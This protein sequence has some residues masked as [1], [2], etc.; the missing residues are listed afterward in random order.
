MRPDN[1]TGMITAA[2]RR[3]EL[4]RAKAVQ[5]LRELDRTGAPVAFDA[6]ARAAGIFRS[7]LYGEADLRAEIQR[8][9]QTTRRSP[10]PPI[11]TAQRASDASL[12]T[13]LQ[14]PQTATARSAR[15]T[16]GYAANSPK[17]SASSARR[18]AD[19]HRHPTTRPAISVQQRLGPANRRTR[20]CARMR[21]RYVPDASAQVNSQSRAELEITI[22]SMILD[23]SCHPACRCHPP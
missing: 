4:T 16:S 23:F 14:T 7:W 18:P 19:R 12:L 8:L 9:R 17:C 10:D 13:R 11:P 15:T 5:A 3:R 2:R 6:V 1:T 22:E 20:D 21:R